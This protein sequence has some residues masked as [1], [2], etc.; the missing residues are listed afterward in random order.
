MFWLVTAVFALHPL[1]TELLGW[2][3]TRSTL[4]CVSFFLLSCHAYVRYL[5]A[6]QRRGKYLIYCALTFVLALFTKSMAVTLP[7]VLIMLDYY[8]KGQVSGKTLLLKTPFFIGS[9]L[10]GL[11]S[12]DSRSVLKSLGDFADYYT[13]LEKAGLSA[14]TLVR[15]FWKAL[16]PGDLITYY[17]YPMKLEEGE[18]L[19]LFYMLS[20]VVLALL[21]LALYLVYK[22]SG[23]TF[24][25]QWLFGLLFFAVNIG[26]Y[27]NFTP[28]GP[29]MW[30]E[31]YM[32]LPLIGVFI[33]LSLLL[34]ELLK[35]A[36]FKNAVY[37]L[38]S[39][40]LVFFAVQSRKQSYVWKNR[41]SLWENAIKGTNAVYPWMELGKA[42]YQLGNVDRAI[43]YFNGGVALNPYYPKVYYF[44]GLA[45]KD[46]GDK[47]YAKVDFERVIEA[48][49]DLVGEAYYER[50]LLYEEAGRLDS[51]MVDYDSA[52]VYNPQSMARIRR[53][54]LNTEG[55]EAAQ[56]ALN[57]RLSKILQRGDSLMSRGALDDALENYNQVL[58]IDPTSQPAL[59]SKGL[60]ASAQGQFPEA[61]QAFD[62]LLELNPNELRGR[63]SRAYAYTQI[64]QFDNAVADY[65]HVTDNL[66]QRT[67]EILYFKAIALANAGQKDQ[68]C[69]HLTEAVDK[70]FQNAVD[71][72]NQLCQ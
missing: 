21:L 47:A 52:L 2:I 59:M 30:A 17:G 14:Y 72:K 10:T 41:I 8:I 66:G 60:I 15:Y 65:T 54:A 70:G 22:K 9:V 5:S 68:A 53:S 28:F 46:M 31:R 63:L 42:Y 40:G 3:S 34:D 11:A 26:L 50:G 61:I 33:C 67:G 49:E 36:S 45:I 13:F 12:L 23:K 20:P 24:R 55:F 6:D 71:L 37:V 16:A 56:N 19:A 38:V 7:I 4:L 62:S 57:Q 29:T 1:Q 69:N 58:E 48:G 44:R 39:A 25:K 18:G 32:Y 51:A 35:I 64:G 27:I 43:E